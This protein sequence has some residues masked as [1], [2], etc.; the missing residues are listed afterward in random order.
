MRFVKEQKR[1]V[2]LNSC[3]LILLKR[4]MLQFRVK[5]MNQGITT[6]DID[7]LILKVVRA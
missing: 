7:K 3:E 1:V 2:E 5:V 6:E 4:A